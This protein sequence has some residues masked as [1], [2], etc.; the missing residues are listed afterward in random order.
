MLRFYVEMIIVL[1]ADIGVT[2]QG[3]V[4]IPLKV[5]DADVCV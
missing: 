4:T 3:T 5:I 1:K 2:P